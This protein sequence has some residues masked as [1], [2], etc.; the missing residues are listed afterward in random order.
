MF[1]H[2]VPVALLAAVCGTALIGVVQ[3][4]TARRTL[5]QR[6]EQFRD[7]LMGDG[8]DDGSQDTP[9]PAAAPK[10]P[11]DGATGRAQA[12][13][14]PRLASRPTSPADAPADEDAPASSPKAS[15]GNNSSPTPAGSKSTKPSGS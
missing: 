11:R 6:L 8:S 5:S 13:Q 14:G 12:P 3:A 9:S 15:S 2:F 10:T 7:D 4:Q 1:R